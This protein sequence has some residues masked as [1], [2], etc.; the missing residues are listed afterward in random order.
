MLKREGVKKGVP[1]LFLAVPKK[2]CG[3]LWIEMKKKGGKV[4]LEQRE[5]LAKFVMQGYQAEV[6]YSF[7]EA[8]DIILRYIS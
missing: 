6:C 2:A 5:W 4:T 3:G 7:E 8:K 1:D